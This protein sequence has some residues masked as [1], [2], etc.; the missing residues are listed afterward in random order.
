V[1]PRPVL[2]LP[3]G[4]AVGRGSVLYADKGETSLEN[5]AQNGKKAAGR[6]VSD[7]VLCTASV[8]LLNIVT[9]FGIYPFLERRMGE[10]AYGNVLYLLGIGNIVASS[11]GSALANFR[12]VQQ[13]GARTSNGD[14]L[15][16][17]GIFCAF[18]F[19]AAAALGWMSEKGILLAL[20]FGL[21]C[22]LMVS[23]NY[24]TVAFR[25]DM[26]FKRFF[27]LYAC[28]AGFALAGLG[29]YLRGAGWLV[30][31]LLS[32][33]SALVFVRLFGQ[34]LRGDMATT[35]H[36][37]FVIK[38]C[39]YLAAG[40]FC[41]VA[42]LNLDRIFLK[43]LVSSEAVTVYYVA[44]LLGKTVA[45]VVGPINSVVLSYLSRYN[46]KVRRREFGLLVAALAVLTCIGVGACRL[47]GPIFMQILYPGVYEKA[48]P[49][50]VVA[51]AAQILY[52]ANDIMMVFL[53]TFSDVK[54]QLRV[55]AVF[56]AVL[57]AADL[58]AGLLGGGLRAFAGVTFA[59]NLACFFGTAALGFW[60]LRKKGEAKA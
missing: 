12:L 23:R 21:L 47:V 5:S 59:V 13:N 41:N 24:V 4:P 36:K 16:A 6:A 43:N 48:M 27:L 31:F 17:L 26:N 29:L 7:L 2:W 54:W 37:N 11:F 18:V 57:A 38:E 22:C 33:A 32:E 46:V 9:Q 45:L 42:A 14:Y 3:C 52:F 40:Y 58:A 10:A 60:N 20:G 49:Y 34:I 1:L 15:R 56:L 8:L 55:Q 30:I 28:L 35:P 50:L 19:P 51:S 39:L 25:L 53:L 44:A